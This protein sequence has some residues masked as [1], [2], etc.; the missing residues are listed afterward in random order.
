MFIFN[1][2]WNNT[3]TSKTISQTRLHSSRMRTAH[4]LTVSP[5][6]LCAWGMSAPG[7]CLLLGDVSR[8][9]LVPE[10]VSWGGV[11]SWGV[12]APRGVG[13]IC[14][15][16]SWCLLGGFSSGGCFFSGGCVCSRGCVCS[17]GVD[18][19]RGWWGLSS[20]G[21]VCSRWGGICSWWGVCSRGW[22]S[23]PACTDTPLLTE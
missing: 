16:G 19:S 12:S 23:I 4:A 8:G 1:E 5:S 20:P 17:E 9:C 6:M 15:S 2:I 22:C 18:Y 13:C 21:G 7:G 3:E 14:S 10:G 11:C